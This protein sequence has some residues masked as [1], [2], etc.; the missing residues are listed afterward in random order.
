MGLVL[1][2]LK[3]FYIRFTQLSIERLSSTNDLL[4]FVTDHY[5][6]QSGFQIFNSISNTE[7]VNDPEKMISK[8][9]DT[10]YGFLEQGEAQAA[11]NHK[12]HAGERINPQ[13]AF[14][15]V[16]NAYS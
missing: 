8:L 2:D 14:L 5:L 15:S 10:I 4:K 3:N 16:F 13:E 1:A 11:G 9:S 12:S 7:K 6:S